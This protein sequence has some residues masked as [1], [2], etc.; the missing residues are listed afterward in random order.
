MLQS[1]SNRDIFGEGVGGKGCILSKYVV[2]T[3]E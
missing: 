2:T 1:R 3:Y